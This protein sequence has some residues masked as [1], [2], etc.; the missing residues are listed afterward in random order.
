M[1]KRILGFLSVG[2]VL[3]SLT[4]SFSTE[5]SDAQLFP[6]CYSSDAYN[7][8][9]NHSNVCID[10]ACNCVGL[11]TVVIGTGVN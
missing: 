6:D 5:D 4:F 8:Y 11:K 3:A 2:L 7:L 1:K 10:F 9:L